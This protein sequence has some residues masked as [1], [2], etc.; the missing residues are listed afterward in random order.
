MADIC[1]PETEA[2]PIGLM[3]STMSTKQYPY[4]DAVA[5]HAYNQAVAVVDKVSPVQTKVESEITLAFNY[6]EFKI[7]RSGIGILTAT[8]RDGRVFKIEVTQVDG[9]K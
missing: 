8:D 7:A 9:P 2:R 4:P 6:D 5:R 1:E 3:E